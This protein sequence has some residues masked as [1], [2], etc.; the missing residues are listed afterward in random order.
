MNPRREYVAYLIGQLLLALG[1]LWL[2]N[3]T[4]QVTLTETISESLGTTIRESGTDFVPFLSISAVVSI[5][6]LLGIIA[7]G[8]VGRRVIG[9]ISALISLV[10]FISLFFVASEG[11][12][13]WLAIA[14]AFL[15]G[16]VATNLFA[17]VRCSRWPQ[18]GG[19]YDRD[20][21]ARPQ[22]DAARDPWKSLDSG[23]DPTLD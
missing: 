22:A 2:A 20:S 15:M 18:L 1:V 3:A 9:V 11:I 17:V 13:G 21:P 14:G 4:W 19:K 8:V 10:A 16:L 7:T 6:A 23:I 12:Y 5:I